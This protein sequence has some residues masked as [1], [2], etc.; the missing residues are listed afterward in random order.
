LFT[1]K[2]CIT[3]KKVGVVSMYGRKKIDSPLGVFGHA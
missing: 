1:I 3:R 2:E